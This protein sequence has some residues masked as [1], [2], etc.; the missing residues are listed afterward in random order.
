MLQPIQAIESQFNVAVLKY[1][2][3]GNTFQEVIIRMSGIHHT[4]DGLT[5]RF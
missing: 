3:K 2:V 4:S 1:H 5:W